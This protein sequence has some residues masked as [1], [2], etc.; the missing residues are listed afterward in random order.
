MPLSPNAVDFPIINAM[1]MYGGSFARAIADAAQR[2]DPVNFIRLK[3]AFPDLWD[4]YA[5][6]AKR[7]A[8]KANTVDASLK[9]GR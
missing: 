9:G 1:A 4:Q 2:A 5:D 3:T 7:Q 8:D 6:L